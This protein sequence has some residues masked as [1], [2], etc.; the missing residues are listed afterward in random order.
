MQTNRFYILAS[1]ALLL[2]L[3][4]LTYGI[5]Q[6]FLAPLAWAV[7]ISIVF[8]PV[9]AYLLKYIKWPIVAS[10]AVLLLITIVLIGPFSYTFYL[11]IDEAR[12]LSE[13]FDR[14]QLESVKNVLNNPTVHQLAKNIGRIFN[15]S[16]TDAQMQKE[17]TENLSKVGKNIIGMIP[18]GIGNVMSAV[19]NFVFMM[20]AVFFILKD[21]AN[22][23]QKLRDYLPFS[24]ENKNAL[25]VQVRDVIVSTIYGGVVVA[26]V[27]GIIGGITYALLGTHSPVLWGLATA[28]SS[29]IP[30]VGT[31]A[32]WGVISVY[33]FIQGVMWKGVVMILVGVLGI[34]MVDNVLKP[35]IIGSK[36]KM[37]I[38]VIFFSV[39]G[40]INMFGLIGLI[41][42]PLVVAVFISVLKIFKEIES[43]SGSS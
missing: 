23:M 33:F 32:V 17:L 12:N 41:M 3:G 1:T 2:L 18:T 37:H 31:F 7:V 16:L 9:Y 21:G 10:L 15:L 38:L 14:G 42:G 20:F 26:I 36:T 11:L 8:Y 27:Q 13:S 35:I 4:Y 43:C 39:L 6:P 30:L 19:A 28:I 5:L 34:S 24:E 25:T 29:F 40:G 22:F